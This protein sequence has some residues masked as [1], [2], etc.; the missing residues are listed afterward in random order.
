VSDGSA[1]TAK[2]SVLFEKPTVARLV[3]E[4]PAIR[5]TGK[6]VTVFA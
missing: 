1:V 2:S 3:K 6:F 5:G 4:F